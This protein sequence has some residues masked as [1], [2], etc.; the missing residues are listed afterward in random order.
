MKAA[1]TVHLKPEVPDNPGK[2]LIKTLNEHGYHEILDVRIGKQVVLDIEGTF[3]G[4]VQSRIEKICRDF[5]A[6][7][8]N[9][10]FEISISTND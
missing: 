8:T 7:N 9:E 1:V 6:S 10:D 4:N 2:A 3:G 5:L